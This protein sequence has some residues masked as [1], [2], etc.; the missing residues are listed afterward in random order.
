MSGPRVVSQYTDDGSAA[1]RSALH[2]SAMVMQ[3]YCLMVGAQ[4]RGSRKCQ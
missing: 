4:D 2:E 3:L 1:I